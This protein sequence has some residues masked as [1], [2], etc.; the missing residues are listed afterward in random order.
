MASMPKSSI[1]SIQ[2]S[3]VPTMAHWNGEFTLLL[4]EE[5]LTI[6]W[7][8]ED[9][10]VVP[11][12]KN[13]TKSGKRL[14]FWNFFSR[15][16]KEP[17]L[18]FQTIPYSLQVSL[19]TTARSF[20]KLNSTEFEWK[21]GFSYTIEKRTVA[22]IYTF[23]CQKIQHWTFLEHQFFSKVRILTTQFFKNKIGTFLNW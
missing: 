6:S 11:R 5:L 12:E 3:I 21:V 20:K 7:Y 1:C 18:Y 8:V 17:V 9:G 23:P 2:T 15:V 16:M 10:M 19:H 14:H 22:Q 4:E 13:A